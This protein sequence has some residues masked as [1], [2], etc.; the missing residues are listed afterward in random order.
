M[1]N[2]GGYL[3]DFEMSETVLNLR[4]GWKGQE[5]RSCKCKEATVSASR[6]LKT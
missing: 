3:N 5:D 2:I 4:K 1:T 6:N